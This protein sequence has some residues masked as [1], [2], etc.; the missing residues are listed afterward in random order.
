[1][2]PTLQ[3][4]DHILVRKAQVPERW[5]IVM[6]YPPSDRFLH[7]ERIVGLPGEVVEIDSSGVK[8]NGKRVNPPSNVGPFPYLELPSGRTF[9]NGSAGHP[10]RLGGDEYFVLGD[11]CSGAGDSRV[12]TEPILNHQPGALPGEQIIGVV[13]ML[14]WPPTRWKQF[15]N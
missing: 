10:I 6:F 14:Y 15:A 13:T 5:D 3:P 8:I 12:W 4:D 2:L 9:S 7:A 1:M 11:N